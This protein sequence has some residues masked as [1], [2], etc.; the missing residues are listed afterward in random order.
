MTMADMANLADR[1]PGAF[2]LENADSNLPPPRHVIQATKKAVG[3]DRYNSYL[4]LHGLPELRKAI[5]RRY[6]AD[7]GLRYEPESEVVVTSGAGE[8][9]LCSLLSLVNPGDRVLLTNP[10]YSGMAQR[11]RLAEG[12]QSFT[13][14]VERDG[15]HLDMEDLEARA[16]GCKVFFVMSPSMPTGTVF[17]E[18]E[19]KFISELA[20]KNDAIV[21]FNAS[22]DKV[23]FD[24]DRVTNPATLP[25]MKDRT[26]VIGSVS[27]NYNM[28]GWRVGWAAGP[29][30]LIGAMENIHIFNG[31][32]PSGINQA[33]ATAAL[34]GP[35]G[36]VSDSVKEY[37]RRRDVLLES[38][39]R[40][41]GMQAV[42]P[43]GG[44][45]FLANTRGLDVKSPEFCL[46]LLEE[47]KVAITPMVAWGSDD[48]G[49]D[50][51]RFIFT[52]EPVR[53]LEEA[54]RRIRKFVQE[55]YT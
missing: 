8:A 14:L 11:V 12:V 39:E 9:M 24:S 5:A 2:R 53:R 18:E 52:N 54:G 26:I 19:T 6:K 51:V 34:M 50:H 46:K 22:L 13:D 45:Y 1:V 7:Y 38:L 35:Q 20:E 40:I 28:M 21:I 41:E 27:K 49:Y 3:G 32:M 15:W 47:T 23:V 37:Q 17:T 36:F 4:P 33:G 55:Y 31:I 25:G 48:F 30:D 29:S 43:E 42:K 10:T 16:K 44:Y